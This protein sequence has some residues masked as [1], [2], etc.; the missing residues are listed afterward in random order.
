[1]KRHKRA[2][3]T[4]NKTK[5]NQISPSKICI[6]IQQRQGREWRMWSSKNNSRNVNYEQCY[7]KQCIT[8]NS[9]NI[10]IKKHTSFK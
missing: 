3:T 1:M 9:E 5:R 4:N 6:K 2:V 7:T 10:F 8:E